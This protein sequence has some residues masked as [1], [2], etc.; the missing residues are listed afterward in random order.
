[1]LSRKRRTHEGPAPTAQEEVDPMRNTLAFLAAA[2][3]TV[4][5][6]GWYLGWYS[7]RPH[8]TSPGKQSY[9]IEIDT[10]KI[11]EDL[12]KGLRSGEQN[13]KKWIDDGQPEGECPCAKKDAVPA[14][15]PGSGTHEEA[16]PPDDT[17][18]FWFRV[19]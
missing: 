9:Q 4:A 3:I 12:S 16:E 1:M 6:V 10:Q 15:T 8:P 17:E 7:V 11:G 18:G 19:N 14:S 5:A 13:V 2:L